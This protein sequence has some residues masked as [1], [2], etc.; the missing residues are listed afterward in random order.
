MFSGM[1]RKS[2]IYFGGN[3][4]SSFLP[5]HRIKQNVPNRSHVPRKRIRSPI[6]TEDG[7]MI[8]VRQVR[9]GAA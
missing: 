9:A 1:S 6:P 7:E 4:Q 3:P 8:R 2:N 5:R